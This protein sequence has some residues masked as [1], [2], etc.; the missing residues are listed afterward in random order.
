MSGVQD[1]QS[2][3]GL[4]PVGGSTVPRAAEGTREAGKMTLRRD[5]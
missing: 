2:V 4:A 1:E 3:S 5:A